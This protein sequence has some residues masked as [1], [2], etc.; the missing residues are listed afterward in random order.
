MAPKQWTPSS[1][2]SPRRNLTKLLIVLSRINSVAEQHNHLSELFLSNFR[3]GRFGRFHHLWLRFDSALH[4]FTNPRQ[5][6][7]VALEPLF[8]EVDTSRIAASFRP[9]CH[10]RSILTRLE[11]SNSIIATFV[12]IRLSPSLCARRG[13]TSRRRCDRVCP[14]RRGGLGWRASTC[15]TGRGK[16]LG[17]RQSA[18]TTLGLAAR[19]LRGVRVGG[20]A[21]ARG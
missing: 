9:L 21:A 17:D 4:Q 8:I 12:V 10:V 13:R 18:A 2:A 19:R 3:I 14:R 11:G 20:A 7:A 15:G 5:H 16:R 1:C 6:L